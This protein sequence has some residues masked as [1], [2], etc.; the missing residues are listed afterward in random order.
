MKLVTP[1]MFML[2]STSLTAHEAGLPHA[3][4]SEATW[5]PVALLIAV[6]LVAVLLLHKALAKS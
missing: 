2:L 1:L 4:T 5:V 3:H 6:A